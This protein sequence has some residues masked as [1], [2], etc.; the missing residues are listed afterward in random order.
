[1]CIRDRVFAA[2]PVLHAPIAIGH[3]GSLE[4]VENTLESVQGAIDA[5]ADYAEIDILLSKD[6]I[7]MVIHDTNLSRLTGD[8]R[9]VYELTAAEPV[10]YTHLDVYKRQG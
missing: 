9:N 7:P 6:S 2:P 5:G 4:G 8:S 1:M 3:R 10:S